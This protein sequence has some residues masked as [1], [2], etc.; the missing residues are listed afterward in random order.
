MG[1][2]DLL[3]GN[4]K[5]LSQEQHQS[6]DDEGKQFFVET[7]GYYDD[8]FSGNLTKVNDYKTKSSQVRANLGWVFKGNDRVASACAAVELKLMQ[9][10]P[11]GDKEEVTSG[12]DYERL[13]RLLDVP[14]YHMSGSVLRKMY[15]SYMNLNGEAYLAK[16]EIF[17]GLP[18]ALHTL[19][20]H[21]VQYR[22][23]TEGN[24]AI[25]FGGKSLDADMVIIDRNPDPVD[26]FR[27]MSVI[28]AAAQTI[29]TE[30]QSKRFNRQFFANSARPSVTVEVPK[31]M[32]PDQFRRFKQQ[33]EEF[34]TGQYNAY[35]PLI[36]EGG[37]KANAFALTQKDMDFLESRKFNKDEIL[38]MFG[39][40]PGMLGM[41]ENVNRSNMEAAEY[42]FAKYE[43]RDRVK[44]FVDILN[45]SLI[46][47]WNEANGTKYEL[48][49][50]NPVPE[51]VKQ[52]LDH[53]KNA[54][55]NWMTVDEVRELEGLPPLP[56]GAGA[57]LMP[58]SAI[59]PE[60]ADESKKKDDEVK[61]LKKKTA[62]LLKASGIL[63]SKHQVK[64][65]A[66]RDYPKLYDG[67]NVDPD[68][69]GCIMANL[70]PLKVLE[71]VEDGEA[72]LVEK[73]KNDWSPLPA[74]DEPHVT[75]LYGLL[76]NGNKW[77]DK[78]DTVLD[79]WN[80]KQVK[81]TEVDYF[82][83]QD[84]IAIVA[85]VEKSP[86]LVDGH[87]RLTLLPHIQTFSEYQPH[88]TL[89]YIQRDN[90]L[91]D[92]WVEALGNAYNGKVVKYKGL[93]Y[94]DPEVVTK[95]LFAQ[96][97]QKKKLA[98]KVK[99][100]GTRRITELDTTLDN[101]ERQFAVET[102]K[103]FEAQRTALMLMIKGQKS[104]SKERHKGIAEDALK[105]FEDSQW[106]IDLS[107]QI[108]PLYAAT[109]KASADSA[110][111]LLPL[112]VAPLDKTDPWVDFINQRA[113]QISKDIN[114]ETQKQIVTTLK[115]GLT[116]GEGVPELTARVESVMGDAASYRA[117][118]IARTEA[119][120]A[121][122]EADL[123]VW[124][125][126][127]IVV[128]KE[129]FTQGGNPCPW[130]ASMQGKV[131]KVRDTY[132]GLGDSHAVSTVN[133]KGETVVQ[134]R[135][136]KYEAIQAPPLHPGCRCIMLPVL[137]NSYTS[138]N[139][140]TPVNKIP[141]QTFYRGT[142]ANVSNGNYAMGNGYYVARDQTT[143]GAFG[144][145]QEV[146]LPLN[147]SD[148]LFIKTQ[149][150]YQDLVNEAIRLY[151]NMNFNDAFPRL[152]TSKGY[153]AVEMSADID[154]LAGIAIYDKSIIPVRPSDLDD[155]PLSAIGGLRPE[156]AAQTAFESAMNLGKYDDAVKI[157]QGIQ[158]QD[159]R[160]SLLSLV[161]T[162]RH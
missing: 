5:S 80:M 139:R 103:L 75:L 140:N 131:V 29:D 92:K 57:V 1:A 117:E 98:A 119:K 18:L 50:E 7:G 41:T 35:K 114:A 36:L 82:D 100:D 161:E 48:D 127:S 32:Q 70:E 2:F 49:F 155:T 145:V 76:E 106:N 74:E 78:V 87:E 128:G 72:D 17:K 96:R 79:G 157:A 62:K 86:E 4:N 8:G 10:Q 44:Q 64:Q 89:A 147:K 134:S 84:S 3:K 81:I 105:L 69:L 99:A 142:G 55:N 95:K 123:Q 113:G 13:F 67:T 58:K 162:L 61:T 158:N 46:K 102:R 141:T 6:V 51:D 136:Y 116:A 129:W 63:G 122:S 94:G 146:K 93:N 111:S 97:V 108:T 107:K 156:D 34:H 28:A 125:N 24:Q 9:I 104:L 151:P 133:G 85:H 14:N 115:Q 52:N 26:P 159:L 73:T 149:D 120:R 132:F 150:Q 25:I 152:I 39:V 110:N 33:F 47:P 135:S 88:M 118:R 21:L 124:E 11:D 23:D 22:I 16:G 91:I 38:A 65:I 144:T 130:C 40:S 12:S 77:K 37:A 27:G 54:V 15:F 137:D 126:S 71:L 121:A 53:R 154:K 138:R 112:T 83:L 90:K 101:F 160:D 68:D 109:M 60:A 42:I 148:I 19:P 43:V 143:A 56:N 45:K 66:A 31:V 153:K 20:S 30:E 59:V